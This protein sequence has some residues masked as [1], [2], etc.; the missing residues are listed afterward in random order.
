MG[1]TYFGAGFVLC[2]VALFAW[3][4]AILVHW[5]N[6]LFAILMAGG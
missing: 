3:P 6:N 4:A 5:I 1:M 2:L